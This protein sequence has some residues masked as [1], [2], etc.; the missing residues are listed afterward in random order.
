V[1]ALGINGRYFTSGSLAGTNERMLQ[2]T[3]FLIQKSRTGT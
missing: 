1:P 2:V 3:D